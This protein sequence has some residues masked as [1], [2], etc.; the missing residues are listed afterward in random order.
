MEIKTCNLCKCNITPTYA[1]KHIH[2][3]ADKVCEHE[4]KLES[5]DLTEM[6]YLN[7]VTSPVQTQL[8]AINSTKLD[9]QISATFAAIGNSLV[10][11]IIMV[12]ADE[13]NGGQTTL[14]FHDGVNIQ[15]FPTQIV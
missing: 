11:R 5:L 4:S 2:E 6:S 10:K 1:M 15:W 14:Y 12:T 8:N 9:F 13:T 3:F 7:G